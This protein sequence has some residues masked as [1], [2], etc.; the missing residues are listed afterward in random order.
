M[1]RY[2]WN[3]YLIK[4]VYEFKKISV[5]QGTAQ[6]KTMLYAHAKGF[7]IIY[8]IALEAIVIFGIKIEYLGIYCIL[9]TF[10]TTICGKRT[11][12]INIF[13]VKA[14]YKSCQSSHLKWQNT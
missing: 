12:A 13:L 2:Y 14:L 6:E 4:L 10:H 3:F 9:W 5:F 8:V 11:Q 1:L 7:F